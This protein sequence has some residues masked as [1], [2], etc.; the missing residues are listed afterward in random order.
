MYE[1][2][3]MPEPTRHAGEL[4]DLPPHHRR[5]QE[6][7]PAFYRRT[8]EVIART[9]GMITNIDANVGRVLDA[10]DRL[11]LRE[12]TVIVYL[13]DHGDLW[14]TIGYN[15]RGLFISVA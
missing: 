8:P 3:E 15:R 12:N 7:R 14:A 5:E 4:D 13:S 10:L 11:N 9:Y 6:R 2:A 1:P